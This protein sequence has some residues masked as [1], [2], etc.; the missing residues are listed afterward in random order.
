[1]TFPN[2]KIR[3]VSSGWNQCVERILIH[4]EHRFWKYRKSV[5]D[6]TRISVHDDAEWAF[7]M[8]QNMHSTLFLK[9]PKRIMALMMVMTLCL[10]VYAALEYRIR[11]VVKAHD[12]TFPDQKNEA[13]M[14]PS[15]RW[16][17]QYFS[18]IHVL[19]IV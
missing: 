15:A 4:R 2:I 9:L 14:T 3:Q 1:M 13:T 8:G 11:G 17:F 5:H 19:T 7:T 12:T 6:E 16:I 18:G 10:L